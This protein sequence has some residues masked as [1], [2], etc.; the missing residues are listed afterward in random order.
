MP[1]P[2]LLEHVNEQFAQVRVV[3]DVASDVAVRASSAPPANRIGRSRCPVTAGITQI[4][5]DQNLGVVE[6]GCQLA[7]PSSPATITAKIGCE[8]R[9]SP[10]SR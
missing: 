9:S 2:N 3:L 6:L 10:A 1:T 5:A 7:F 4:A 8:T